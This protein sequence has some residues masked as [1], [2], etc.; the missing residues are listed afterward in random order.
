MFVS[1]LQAPSLPAS[2]LC[3]SGTL[4]ISGTGLAFLARK[5]TMNSTE[6]SPQVCGSCLGLE[7]S[8]SYARK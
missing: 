8:A 5:T 2:N 3:C 7:N 6:K 1:D 4:G